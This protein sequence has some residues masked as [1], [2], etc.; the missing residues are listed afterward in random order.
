M[1][2]L[3]LVVHAGRVLDGISHEEST[4]AQANLPDSLKQTLSQKW[5]KVRVLSG[6]HGVGRGWRLMHS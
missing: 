1:T 2:E 4:S 5:R 3:G 6:G